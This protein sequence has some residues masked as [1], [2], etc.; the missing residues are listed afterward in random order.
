M[1]MRRDFGIIILIIIVLIASYTLYSYYSRPKISKKSIINEILKKS[2]NTIKVYSDDFN[3]QDYLS[4]EF[5][6]DGPDIS[7]DIKWKNVPNG[8]KSIA[9]IIYDPDAPKDYFIHWI[10]YDLPPNIYDLPRGTSP[11]GPILL[12]KEG[13][14]DFGKI[15][16]KGPCPPSGSTH[17]Y[18]FLV[19]ALN[20]FIPVN[21]N[22][23]QS[24]LLSFIENH[25]IA[26]GYITALY[27]R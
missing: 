18:V 15:G 13:K 19:V 7:P 3:D 20:D 27:N 5:T 8:T 2:K 17:R 26:Y 14:N 11:G 16:Y 6:C 1:Y 25:V 4:S 9:I 12:G 21:K 24:D 22:M 23:S 10:V